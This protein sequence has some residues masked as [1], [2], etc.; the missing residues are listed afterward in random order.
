MDIAAYVLDKLK[1]AGHPAV[2]VVMPEIADRATWR[3]IL[4]EGSTV[5]QQQAAQAFVAGLTIAAGTLTDATAVS[6]FDDDKMLKAVAIWN[7]QKE[8]VPL[9]IARAEILAI[10]RNL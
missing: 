1:A 8:G 4:A 5:E 3:V 2:N 7:A 10:Y 9:N 6:R